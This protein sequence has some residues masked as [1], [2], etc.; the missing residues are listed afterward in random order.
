MCARAAGPTRP[1]PC[2]DSNIFNGGTYRLRNHPA[3]LHACTGPDRGARW[4]TELRAHAAE[5]AQYSS[6]QLGY[7][8]R[9]DGLFDG[10]QDS[11]VVFDFERAG[12]AVHLSFNA[13]AGKIHI[14][15][16]TMGGKL[17]GTRAQCGAG[18]CVIENPT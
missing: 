5:Q 2:A 6:T 15:G 4:L 10:S 7:G 14:F 16:A 11:I 17:N 18:G 12:S 1:S 13:A 3:V 9:L 8:L